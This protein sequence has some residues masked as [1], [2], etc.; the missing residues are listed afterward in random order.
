M[1]ALGQFI[2]LA[3]AWEKR[4]VVADSQPSVEF[5][6]PTGDRSG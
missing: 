6:Q 1:Q 2:S 4:H 5:Y 3:K